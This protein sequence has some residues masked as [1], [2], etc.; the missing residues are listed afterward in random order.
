MTP[1]EALLSE[2]ETAEKK[3]WWGPWR[4]VHCASIEMNQQGK[5]KT[6]PKERV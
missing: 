5:W 1:L 3:A 2:I 4:K 6:E